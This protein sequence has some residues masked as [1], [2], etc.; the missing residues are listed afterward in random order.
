M[1]LGLRINGL[2]QNTDVLIIRDWWPSVAPNLADS[3]G[4]LEGSRWL[5][6]DGLYQGVDEDS[7][8]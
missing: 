4:A 6:R 7:G 2:P 3:G 5:A 1:C 8:K